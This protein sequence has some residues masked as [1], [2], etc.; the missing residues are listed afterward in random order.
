MKRTTALATGILL[1]LFAVSSFSFA[2]APKVQNMPTYDQSPYHFGFIL[3]GNTMYFSI[4]PKAN[5]QDDIYAG[6]AVSNLNLDEASIYGI[7]G[8]STYGFSVGIVGNLRLGKYSDLRFVPSLAFGERKLQYTLKGTK[9]AD[10]SLITI[11]DNIQST[12]ID[13]PLHIK[14]KSK[15]MH[16]MRAYVFTGPK[17]SIDLATQ[18]DDEQDQNPLN[19]ELNRND[20]YLDIG[21]GFD[22]YFSFFKFGTELKMSYGLMNMIKREDNIYTQG[23]DNLRS[24]IFQLSF[25]FE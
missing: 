20:V 12:F 3:A 24:K 4:D 2:Q 6:D 14:Y 5:F 17:V 18:K 9:G 16:N 13:L 10:T 7:E 8:I 11:D 15:R 25:T 19:L 1:A 22:W 23:I 21:V